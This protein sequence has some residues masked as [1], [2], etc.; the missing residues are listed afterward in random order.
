MSALSSVLRWLDGESPG[1]SSDGS[2]VM[3]ISKADD[4]P[5][6]SA[7]LQTEMSNEITN[8]S[9]HPDHSSVT[10]IE[11][12]LMEVSTKAVNAVRDWGSEYITIRLYNT[13]RGRSRF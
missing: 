12:D 10:A 13:R 2:Q 1:S 6:V 5:D 8:D 11:A 4:I 7:H 9:T 3:S